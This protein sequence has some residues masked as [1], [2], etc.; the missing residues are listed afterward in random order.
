MAWALITGAS[1]GLGREFADIAAADGYS[2]ILVARQEDRL[3]AL[4]AELTARHG[5]DAQAIRADLSR[6]DEAERLWSEASQGREID[7]L[8]NNAGLG[9]NG[10]FADPQSWPREEASL[11]VNAVA[12]TI[13]M[14]RAAVDMAAR[15]RGRILNVASLAGFVAGPN[16]AVYHATKAYALSLSEAVASEL[17]GSGVTVTAL[18]PGATR[19][20]FFKA[21]EAEAATYLTRLPLPSARSVAEAGWRGMKAGRRVIVPG[22]NN[23]LSAV[24]PRLLPRKWAVAVTGILLARR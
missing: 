17:S 13:L 12:L 14:K 22:L 15:G 20:E 3:T 21:D 6:A 1:A 18:C 10:A 8:V 9:R 23:K 5:I 4:A 19:T 2:L 11:A 24:L 16:M 7:I